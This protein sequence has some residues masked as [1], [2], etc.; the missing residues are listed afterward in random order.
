MICVDKKQSRFHTYSCCLSIF[1]RSHK[2]CSGTVLPSTR[3]CPKGALLQQE[4]VHTEVEFPLCI[5]ICGCFI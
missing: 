3:F 2:S 4:A 1:G 5:P